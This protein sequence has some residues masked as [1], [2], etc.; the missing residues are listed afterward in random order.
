M[1]DICVSS[2]LYIKTHQ[3]SRRNNFLTIHSLRKH[4]VKIP[5]SKINKN[6]IYETTNKNMLR[7]D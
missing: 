5:K 2:Y 7:N 4:C 3:N 6:L 1:L